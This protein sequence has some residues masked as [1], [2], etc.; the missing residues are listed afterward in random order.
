MNKEAQNIMEICLM[1]AVVVVL[2]ISVS[3]VYNNQKVKLANLSKTTET[4]GINSNITT[5]GGGKV[6]AGVASEGSDANNVSN[7]GVGNDTSGENDTTT[8][9]DGTKLVKIVPGPG[10]FPEKVQKTPNKD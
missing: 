3:M 1:S 4:A 6:K 8:N 5:T 2:A 7:P 10:M 9:D